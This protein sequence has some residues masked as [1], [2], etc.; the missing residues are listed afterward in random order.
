MLVNNAIKAI[1]SSRKINVSRLV[2]SISCWLIVL[3]ELSDI[4][5]LF[6]VEYLL[7]SVP[8]QHLLKC[9]KNEYLL[10]LFHKVVCFDNFVVEK[11]IRFFPV[12]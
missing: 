3:Y 8:Y 5:R 1:Y 2:A 7:V 6:L 12:L 4:I 10:F 11:V 9:W